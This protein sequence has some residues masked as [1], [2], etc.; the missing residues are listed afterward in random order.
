[1]KT[2]S[3]ISVIM[4]AYNVEKYIEKAIESI[5]EQSYSNIELLIC[6][7]GSVDKTVEII[8]QFNDKRIYLYRNEINLGNLNTTNFLFS[9]CKG[10]FIALQDADDFS[11]IN[12]LELLVNQF[13]LNDKLGIVGSYYNLVDNDSSIFQCGLI[14]TTNFLIQKEME[15]EVAPFLYPSVMVKKQ[16]FDKIGGFRMFFNRK[17]YA[18][19]DWMARICEVS[20]GLNINLPLYNYRKHSDSFTTIALKKEKTIIEEYMHYLI[21]Q[22]HKDRLIG[23][24]DFFELN[25]E[26]KMLKRIALKQC[27]DAKI[28]YWDKNKINFPLF[29]KAISN[30]PFNFKIYKDLFYIVR[31]KIVNG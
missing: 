27:E 25:D 7:D 24:K 26:S 30:D 20:E 21:L 6:D 11:E 10:D 19:F 16:V 22:A 18:D 17:G 14:P 28:Y 12:R 13:N 31:K 4:P 3:L 8:N 23:K 5:L 2:N 29:F 1:M 15:I 9:K